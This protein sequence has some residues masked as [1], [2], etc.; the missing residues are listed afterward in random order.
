MSESSPQLSRDIGASQFFT[1]AFG[2]IIGVGWVVALSA[3][4][5]QAGPVGAVIGFVGGGLLIMLVGLCY[6]EISTMFPVSGGEVVL[7]V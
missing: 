2:S 5:N 4:L 7:H 1:L 3:W 6:V